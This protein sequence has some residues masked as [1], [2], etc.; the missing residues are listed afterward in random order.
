MPI[1]GS[2][3]LARALARE[4]TDAMF[5]LMGAP[6]L[7]AGKA[8]AASGI[9]MID[10]RHEQA[11]AMMAHAH[12]RIRARPGVCMA[13]SGPGTVNL[14]AG[15]ANA[16]IDGAPVIALGGASSIVDVDTGAFQEIDQVAVMRPVTKY[17]E[18]V[19][20][21]RRI[22]EYV[23]RSFARAMAGKPGPVYLDLPG[24]VLYQ[25]VEAADV[26]WPDAPRVGNLSQPAA[27]W[28]A[29]DRLVLLLRQ[30]KR[31]IIVAGSGA[32]WSQA[33]DELQCLVAATGIPFYTTPPARGLVPEDDA[34]S[35]LGARSAAF[36]EADVVLVVGSR[37]NYVLGFG[38]PPRFS[39]TARFARIDIDPKEICCGGR[40]DLGIVGD[41]KT[42]L[43]QLCAQLP[44]DTMKAAYVDWREHL[45]ALD[46]EHRRQ[47][48]SAPE[49]E[50][51]PIHP[52]RLCQEVRDFMDRDA[53]L[54]A[55]GQ[56]ILHYSRHV[57]A[58]FVPGHRLGPGPF[59]ALGVGVPFALGAK[60]AKPDK[61]VILLSGD[62]SFGLNALELDTAIRHRLPVLVVISLNGGWTA[63]AG[64]Q[65][66]G[67]ELGYTRYDKLAESLGCHG[68]FVRQPEDI[69]PAL[70]RAAHAVRDGQAAVV[71]VV[72]DSQARA[73]T[74]PYARYAT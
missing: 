66:A 45:S 58:S 60:A 5:F 29:L 68:E 46:A 13:A 3:L 65:R 74:A 39:P 8:C 12:A 34:N 6:I 54:V 24:D 35:F 7:D 41:A 14:A 17:A 63:D 51:V 1:T 28:D 30:A 23:R 64:D 31:P 18:R 21:A 16:L 33:A 2:T 70:E 57:I 20:E 71:N 73:R 40:I 52:L 10:V 69:R 22:P 67:R 19:Y 48:V 15:L 56:E 44:G 53:I 25:E 62:G 43:R 26:A 36:A 72:T 11:A 32:L 42:V 55:D 4:G 61:Q 50:Q 37:L 47:Q 9:R 59:G 49:R 38:R 27:T